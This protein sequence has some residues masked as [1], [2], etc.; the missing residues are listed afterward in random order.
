MKLIIFGNIFTLFSKIRLTT[1]FLFLHYSAFSTSCI[2]CK[3]IPV[4]NMHLFYLQRTES[5]WF[6]ISVKIEIIDPYW[7]YVFERVICLKMKHNLTLK[8]KH[9][10]NKIN[11]SRFC[12]RNVIFH[13]RILYF[14]FLLWREN[15]SLKLIC[16]MIPIYWF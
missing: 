8:D 13:S 1:R 15:L 6:I 7:K 2:N 12:L 11:L 16:S 5:I 14:V 3:K 4:M 9:F 10:E